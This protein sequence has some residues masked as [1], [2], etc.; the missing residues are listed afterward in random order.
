ML[1]KDCVLADHSGRLGGKEI[2]TSIVIRF[3][4]TH[5]V[6]SKRTRNSFSGNAM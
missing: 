5:H 4:N 6:I 1:R 3:F 2:F